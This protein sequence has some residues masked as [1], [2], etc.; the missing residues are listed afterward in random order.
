MEEKRETLKHILPSVSRETEEDL[1]RYEMLVRKWQPHINLVANA[2]LTDLWNRHILDSV[3][4]FPLHADKKIWLDLGSGGGFPGI[5]LAVLLKTSGGYMNLI[6]SNSKKASFLRTVIAELDLP[7]DVHCFRI[8]T[9]V[10]KIKTPDIITARALAALDPLLGLIQPFMGEKTVS[11]LQ[12]GRDYQREIA[13]A[14]KH[15]TFDLVKH[16]SRVDRESVILEVSNLYKG[17]KK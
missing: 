12:K 14:H 6:E 11:L 17:V 7:A 16:N 15:W 4:L 8:E 2:A 9:M 5:V 1:L 3:Q 13:E 10:G